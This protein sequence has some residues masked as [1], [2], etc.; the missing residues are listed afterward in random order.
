M[1]VVISSST[2]KNKNTMPELM[3]LQLLALVRRWHRTTPNITNQIEK[4]LI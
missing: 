4:E 1:E 3:A 2:N